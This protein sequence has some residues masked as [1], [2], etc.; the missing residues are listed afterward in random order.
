MLEY[1]CKMSDT[2]Y[3]ITNE[4]ENND[5]Y[6]Y[7]NDGLNI[8]N[9]PFVDNGFTF[10]NLKHIYDFLDD[11]VYLRIITLPQDDNDFK[12]VYNNNK[13]QW[14]AN[15]IILGAKYRLDNI[16]TFKFLES[17]NRPFYEIPVILKWSIKRGYSDIAKY[18]ID[19]AKQIKEEVYPYRF[20]INFTNVLNLA[21]ESN[22]WSVVVY[23]NE[24]CKGDIDITNNNFA[25]VQAVNA[26]NLT[27]V[28]FLINWGMEINYE[29]LISGNGFWYSNNKI[30]MIKYFMEQGL[31]IQISDNLILRMAARYGYLNMVEYALSKG[32]D[33]CAC[34]NSAIKDASKN[35]HLNVIKCLVKHGADLGANMDWMIDVAR[36]NGHR[37]VVQYLIK[38]GGVV[39]GYQITITS[40]EDYEKI[41]DFLEESNIDFYQE[42]I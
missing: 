29:H 27:M 17:I 35:G 34:K 38:K 13:K 36:E 11:G 1:S 7:L 41:K 9:K 40:L 8:L 33:V 4:K 3:K 22:Q 10:T 21:A 16:S 26:N 30:D 39:K 32:A 6:Q 31:D 2:F 18:F 24:K 14:N 23:L 5:N 28:K 20:P 15:K 42:M 37:D 19:M 12:M 25:C